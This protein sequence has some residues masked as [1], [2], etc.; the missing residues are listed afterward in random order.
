MMKNDC[1]R[2]DDDDDGDEEDTSSL[3]TASE[4]VVE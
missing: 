1:Y 4:S 2:D 3:S